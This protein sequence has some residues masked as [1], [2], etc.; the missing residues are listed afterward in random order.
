[1]KTQRLR[2]TTNTLRRLI[3][4]NATAHIRNLCSKLHPA[5][6]AAI[7]NF[8]LKSE[9]A[10][11]FNALATPE[12]K[13]EVLSELPAALA[14]E[15]LL[16]LEDN[17]LAEILSTLPS[18]DVADILSG[19][20]EEFSSR[21]LALLETKASGD[22]E[23]LLNYAE[24][25]AGRIMSPD[26][27][28][29]PPTT[30]VGEAIERLRQ[31]G[32]DVEMAFYVYVVDEEDRLI[33]VTSIR[34][35]ITTRPETPLSEIIVQDVISVRPYD[36]QEE[37]ARFVARYNLLAIPV[38]D[39]NDRMLGI[40]TVDDVVDVI[41]EEATED[42]FRMAGTDQEE[43]VVDSPLT[44]A[45]TRMP[46]L[47]LRVIAGVIAGLLLYGWGLPPERLLALAAF[48]PLLLGTAST[49][50]M[51]ST[52]VVSR[53][54]ATGLLGT[55]LWRKVLVREFLAGTLQGLGFGVLS[56]AAA[57]LLTGDWHF[58]LILGIALFVSLLISV[59][60]G[61]LTPMLFERMQFDPS[62]SAAPLVPAT[63]D[64]LSLVVYLALANLLLGVA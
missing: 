54:L 45:R 50:G 60:L 27:F 32:D 38:V 25:T 56:A 30:T 53:G 35:L 48:I 22:V 3:R 42:L 15:I 61:S 11:V 6:I 49:A 20:P 37:V 13:G 59:S 23:E 18:D 1:M 62:T 31:L 57:S 55:P 4:R 8:L 12:R 58:A 10:V 16:E 47:L 44:T 36:D 5:D 46:W 64:L 33:G 51:Q 19:L 28:A 43:V 40:V 7:F 39:D 24:K 63:V 17:Q 14:S 21:A 26:F 34:K 2:M 41:K 52:I 29:L 9:R